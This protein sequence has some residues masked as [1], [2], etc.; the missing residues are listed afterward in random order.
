M[1]RAEIQDV[2]KGPMLK[3]SGRLAGEWAQEAQALVA[4]NG[5]TKGLVVDLTEICYIDSSGEQLLH[6]LSSL[7]AQ[8]VAAN[9][10]VAGILERLHL[11]LFENGHK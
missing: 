9:I 2:A 11:P 1:F 5:G 3:M 4:S 7:G 8:F 6:W 10:Y